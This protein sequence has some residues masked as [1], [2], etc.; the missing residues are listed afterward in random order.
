MSRSVRTQ[1]EVDVGRVVVE[2]DP[3]EVDSGDR[4]RDVD[5]LSPSDRRDFLDAVEGTTRLIDAPGLAAGDVVR[6]TAYYRV[7]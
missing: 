6:F 2:C 7:V 3:A 4:V 1:G 5:Q